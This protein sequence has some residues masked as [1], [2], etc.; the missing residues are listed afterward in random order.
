M[1]IFLGIGYV[2][3]RLATVEHNQIIAERNDQANAMQWRSLG[4]IK[5]DVAIMKGTLE[6]LDKDIDRLMQ[7]HI[8]H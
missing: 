6:H 2:I 1:L 7:K 5:E 4:K 3:K 8:K